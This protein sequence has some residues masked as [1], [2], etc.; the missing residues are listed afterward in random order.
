MIDKTRILEAER[1][2]NRYIQ[3]GW[4]ILKR[5]DNVKN[6][7]FFMHN[8]QTSILTAQALLDISIDDSK[9]QAIGQTSDFESYLW[10]VV[11]SYYSMFYASLALLA[12]NEM[13]VDGRVHQ[14]VEDVLIAR[15][16]GNR[17]LANLLEQYQ[18]TKDKAQQIMGSQDLAAKLV[19]DFGLERQKRNNLQYELGKVAK[20]N[21]AQTSLKR[22]SEFISEIRMIVHE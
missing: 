2:V 21:L 17:R 10:V 15:F 18:E 19:N 6:A 4:L 5:E 8:A 11:S 12:R 16:L 3:D 22:A 14:V 20:Q 13:K 7:D 1:N 9:K